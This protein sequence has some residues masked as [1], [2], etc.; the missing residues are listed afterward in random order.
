MIK[1]ISV[2]LVTALLVFTLTNIIVSAASDIIDGPSIIHKEAN[3]VFTVS[4][5][6]SL[7]DYDVFIQ[8]D[9]FTGNG[10][11][12]GEYSV[13]LSQ[14]DNTKNVTIIVVENWANLENSTD[15]LF[16]TD[17]KNIYVSNDRM[18]TLYEILYYIYN[19]TGYIDTD[20][21]FRY[22]EFTNTYFSS[23]N[24]DGSIDAGIY[25][26]TFRL[27]YFSGNQA[28]YDVEI[29]TKKI[30]INGITIE[31]PESGIKKFI[32]Y[33]PWLIGIMIIIYL[34]KHKKKKGSYNY[35]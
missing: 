18:L 7:Y 29:H 12:P 23:F 35:D 10:N 8:T 2:L 5:L 1:K 13:L 9:N 26:I 33:F 34:L 32:K 15:V 21:Q 14:D 28:S 11:V 20:Y 30:I 19:T 6:L 31:P 25:Q 27:T 17:Y 22:E 4:D 24:D 3:Q 16:V